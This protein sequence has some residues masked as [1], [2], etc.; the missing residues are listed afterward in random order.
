[1]GRAFQKLEIRRE[2][3]GAFGGFGGDEDMAGV[4]RGLID[5]LGLA[6]IERE[7]F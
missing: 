1:L 5:D 6:E 4:L 3:F 2:R 7:L